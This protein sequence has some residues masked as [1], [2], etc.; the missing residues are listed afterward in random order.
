MTATVVLLAAGIATAQ[1]ASAAS[2]TVYSPS[3]PDYPQRV[4][5]AVGCS[6]VKFANDDPI[7]YPNQPGA[8]HNHTFGGNQHI[9]AGSTPA[10]LAAGTTNCKQ[11]MD[12]AAYWT[13]TIYA[14]GKALTPT[15]T[16]AYYRAGTTDGAIVKPVPFGLQMLAGNP[17]ATSP[18]DARI[19]GFHCRNSSGPTVS[20]QALPPSCPVGS[21]LEASVIFPNCWDGVNLDSPDHRSHMSYGPRTAP[22]GCDSAHPVQLSQLTIAQRYPID[23]TLGKTVTLASGLSAANSKYTL[24][25]DFMNAW[26]PATMKLL[27][28]RCIN[29]SVACADVTDA[30]MPPAP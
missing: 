21:F 25:A 5:F 6:F 12:K 30:R 17:S 8:S 16:R 10:S 20:K 29:A 2:W 7:V 22:Y 27:T 19:A 23:A 14:N 18:Q 4:D 3:N 1:P 24:H 26:D 11:H 15:S 28:E 13:P 9:H